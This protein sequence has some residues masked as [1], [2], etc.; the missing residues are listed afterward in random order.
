MISLG[1]GM[2]NPKTFPIESMTFRLK[3]GS[4]VDVSPEET[5]KALQYSSTKGLPPLHAHLTNL[6]SNVHD[7]PNQTD[8]IITN[9]SQDALSK[10]FEMLLTRSSTLLVE[11]PTYSG[12][13]A[14]LK[15][16]EVNLLPVATDEYGL[17]PDSLA[18]VLATFDEGGRLDLK[19]PKVLYTIP[20]GSN[21]S[22]GTLSLDRKK[23]L[24]EIAC[25]HDLIILED[26]P[27]Y[28]I[29]FEEVRPPSLLSMDVES[30]VIR[31][32]S[33]SKLLSA[34]MRV[35]FATGPPEL[36]ERMELHHQATLLHASGVSQI[37][38][39]ALFDHWNGITGFLEHCEKVTDFYKGQ[40][41]CFIK[42][43]KKHLDGLVEMTAPTAGMFAWMKLVGVENSEDLVMNKAVSEN[44]LMVPGASFLPSAESG[45]D[46]VN[47]KSPFVRCSF[48][49]ATEEE[50]DTA[51]ERLGN[52]LRTEAA[53]KK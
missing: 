16:M 12:S 31:F 48:S 23:R 27:Y 44:I 38:V 52:L 47:T 43:A 35:G 10:A 39:S 18:S 51:L 42:A 50:I 6:Q 14:F 17:I 37:I 53:R 19:K 4:T 11:S 20:T 3:N 5:K 8:I 15:P 33:F 30:R 41:D 22:G 28:Y 45:S 46:N 24:Y 21:P 13:L 49:T 40:R 7:P 25:K 26:D 1:G 36:I 29:N 2:P 32:D 9:G 34:G